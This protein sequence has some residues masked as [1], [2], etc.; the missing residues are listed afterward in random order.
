MKYILN[1]YNQSSAGTGMLAKTFIAYLHKVKDVNDEFTI[2]LPRAPFYGDL[3]PQQKDGIKI[4]YVP[5][6]RGVKKIVF[7]FF[8]DII[9]FPMI[10]LFLRPRGV[11]VFGNFSVVPLLFKK[12]VLCHHPHLVDDVLLSKY[13]FKSRMLER[14]KRLLFFLTTLSC[15]NVVVESLFMKN[16][17]IKKYNVSEESIR[18]IRN[19]ISESL[20]AMKSGGEASIPFKERKSILYVSRFSLHKNYGFLLDLA[21][22]YRK[23]IEKMQLEFCITIDINLNREA[24]KLIDDIKTKKLGHIIKNLG[25]LS[26]EKLA[27]YY[28][29]SLCLFF[30]SSSETFGIPLVEAMFFELPIILPNLPYAY[31]MRDDSTLYYNLDNYEDAFRKICYI[32]NEHNWEIY[33]EKSGQQFAKFPSPEEWVAKYLELL[34]R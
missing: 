21:D 28:Q 10:T 33:S 31:S 14:I 24:N 30:P 23:D 29:K 8:Y 1:F 22:K 5:F 34:K 19:S 18:V 4:F 6:F 16:A 11:L 2:I 3:K 26:H 25:E 20:L 7:R 17:L 13:G 15:G 12:V 32:C 27:P 9:I